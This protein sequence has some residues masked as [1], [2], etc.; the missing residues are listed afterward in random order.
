[1]AAS[2][3][4]HQTNEQHEYSEEDRDL[5]DDFSYDY[6]DEPDAPT[7]DFDR[8]ER[9]G[10]HGD[11]DRR[12]RSMDRAGVLA[13]IGY[14][15]D[16]QWKTPAASSGDESCDRCGRKVYPVERVDIGVIYHR[17]CFRWVRYCRYM[18]NLTHIHTPYTYP[19]APTLTL[20]FTH[21]SHE[22]TRVHH[23]TVTQTD[24]F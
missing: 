4:E 18:Y 23:H 3:G 2:H 14:R 22:Q 9:T 8:Q 7:G 21:T 13:A 19:V 11:V 12:S 10:T 6:D 16:S 15:P 5:H 1:M 17:G 20:T 24:F